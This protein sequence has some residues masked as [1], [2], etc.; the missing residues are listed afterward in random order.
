MAA[1]TAVAVAKIIDKFVD[2]IRIAVKA[3]KVRA[4][5]IIERVGVQTRE[6]IQR[7]KDLTTQLVKKFEDR[8]TGKKTTDPNVRDDPF[9]NDIKATQDNYP[10]SELPRSYEMQ[11]GENRMWVH[12][13]ATEHMVE[14]LQHMAG[15]GA[16][17]E[18]LD[19]ATQAQMK[20]LQAAAAEASRDGVPYN[21]L[22]R[23]GG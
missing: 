20:S 18:Q 14:Y 7:I 13:N 11:V 3:A 5:V 22:V 16:T 10:G 21:E 6:T 19:L 4:A 23:V 9:W 1:K 2:L 8:R 12:G 15:R 17:K